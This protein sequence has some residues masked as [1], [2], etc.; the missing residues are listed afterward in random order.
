MPLLPTSSFLLLL[1]CFTFT[2]ARTEGRGRINHQVS[3]RCLGDVYWGMGMCIFPKCIFSTYI[4]QMRQH[5]PAQSD[6]DAGHDNDDESSLMM[7]HLTLKYFQQIL[8]YTWHWLERRPKVNI[9]H[10]YHTD[11]GASLTKHESGAPSAKIILGPKNVNKLGGILTHFS[12]HGYC[13]SK[14]PS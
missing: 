14:S 1:T 13:W 11:T 6:D 4:F 9:F 2:C 3:A 5:L 10:H 12:S 7:P 8:H